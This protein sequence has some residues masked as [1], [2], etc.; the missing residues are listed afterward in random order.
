MR[1]PCLS[2]EKISKSKMVCS[3][4]C[5]ALAEYQAF[6][7][8]QSSSSESFDDTTTLPHFLRYMHGNDIFFDP[9]KDQFF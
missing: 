4:K 6:L 8:N 3:K 9:F 5:R 7:K 1:S 2:C